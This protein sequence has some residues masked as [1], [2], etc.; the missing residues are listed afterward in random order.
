MN[1]TLH[2]C[3]L[4]AVAISTASCAERPPDGKSSAL[5]SAVILVIRHAEKPA[6]GNELNADGKARARAYV[7]YFQNFTVDGERLKL[8]FLYAAADSKE[9]HRPRL[10]L[11]PT[12]KKLGLAI[13][14][15]FGNE[16][17]QKLADEILTKPRGK[18]ILICW[19]HGEIPQLVQALGANSGQLFPK[20]KWPDEV[21]DWVIQLRYD[22]AGRLVEAKRIN[23]S[24]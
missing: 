8:D 5:K 4:L 19:H 20:G 6:K 11:E 14:S 22:S 12:S 24:F 21:Y 13:N 2:F 23:E 17:F 18:H 7:N 1:L 3:G 16:Q 15:R 9:S 10:T